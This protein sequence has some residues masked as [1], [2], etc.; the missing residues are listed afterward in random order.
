MKSLSMGILAC[1]S[2]IWEN[3]LPKEDFGREAVAL[4]INTFLDTYFSVTASC[5]AVPCSSYMDALGRLE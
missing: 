4:P 5:K 3:P 2:S 1:F